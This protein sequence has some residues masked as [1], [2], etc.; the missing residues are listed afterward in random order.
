MRPPA[1]ERPRQAGARP[2]VVLVDGEVLRVRIRRR[3]AAPTARRRGR[4]GAPYSTFSRRRDL[5]VV[6]DEEPVE[7]RSC[8]WRSDR[9]SP[10]GTSCSRAD[11]CRPTPRG[12]HRSSG[13]CTRSARRGRG[14]R[15]CTARRCPALKPCRPRIQLTLSITCQMPCLKSKPTELPSPMRGP[16]NWAMPVT[17]IAGPSTAV[18]DGRA[19]L[20]PPRVLHAQLVQ[21]STRRASTPAAPRPSPSDR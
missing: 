11:S 21:R 20:V 9:R 13:T 18:G 17:V 10:A 8:S 14:R 12:R 19:E 16:P 4:S 15:Q 3:T 1:V 7:R 2:P 6:L 5:P